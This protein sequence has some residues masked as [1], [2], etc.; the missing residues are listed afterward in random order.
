[1]ATQKPSSTA[2]LLA[3]AD[4]NP[5]RALMI[6]GILLALYA[7]FKI[8]GL[9][10]SLMLRTILPVALL[11]VALAVLYVGYRMKDRRQE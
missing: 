11:I 9:M 2:D 6:V 8:V 4:M 7:V 5:G 1:M 10:A 3:R